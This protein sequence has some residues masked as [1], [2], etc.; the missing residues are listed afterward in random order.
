[1]SSRAWP[2]WK[3]GGLLCLL[4]GSSWAGLMAES[5]RVVFAAGSAEQSLQLVNTNPYPVVVQ[6][7]VDGGGL[8]S[9]PDTA[10]AAVMPI[11]PIFR[12]NPQAQISLRLIATGVPLPADR[13]SLFWLNLYEIPPR[14]GDLPADAQ[15]LTV[16]LRTQ[17]K[18]F[19]RPAKLPS[20]AEQLPE[21]LR[22]ALEQDADGSRLRIA[23]PSP[24][25]ATFRSLEVVCAGEA[26]QPLTVDMLAPLARETL[27]LATPLPCA[28]EAA[29]ARFLLVDDDGNPVAGRAA[30]GTDV[31]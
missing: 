13:E 28:A 25:Y 22:F 23:N 8:E 27:D 19:M 3:V 10:S 9:G 6:A 12:L 14:P 5:T 30:L 26:A 24:Y 17:M 31:E 15:T 2:C 18:L 4:C 16:T 11:P 7:W 21:Q 20:S 29:E 1:M